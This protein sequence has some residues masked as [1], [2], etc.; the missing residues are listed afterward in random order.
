[1]CPDL[2]PA[3]VVP[4]L[5]SNR[6]IEIQASQTK[7]PSHKTIQNPLDPLRRPV[8]ISIPARTETPAGEV[9][10]STWALDGF[11]AAKK[12][13]LLAPIL[14]SRLMCFYNLKSRSQAFQRI[15]RKPWPLQ[16]T[17]AAGPQQL[18]G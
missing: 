7:P 1:M 9:P 6:T 2:R 15:C 16:S 11:P 13:S 8:Q 3:R 4:Q 5:V 14:A 12:I 17:Y 10:A 18:V